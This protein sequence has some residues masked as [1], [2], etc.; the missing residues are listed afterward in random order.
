MGDASRTA[1]SI[2]GRWANSGAITPAGAAVGEL[3][4][5][6]V[7]MPPGAGSAVGASAGAFVGSGAEEL[8]NLA[9][10]LW[11]R[12]ARN[13]DRMVRTAEH[14]AQIPALN[15]LRE[16]SRDPRLVELLAQAA[17]TAARSF[18]DWKIDTLARVFVH[19]ARGEEHVDGAQI[20]L[21]V[22]RQ[23]ERPHLRLMELLLS[24]NPNWNYP[25]S[26]DDTAATHR[27]PTGDIIQVDPGL[28]K[29]LASRLSS[30]RDSVALLRDWH[31]LAT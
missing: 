9:T 14:E 2:V 11:E 29:A 13:V 28:D 1:A 23:L 31:E 17:E 22:V 18:D 20:V 30:E 10:P 16:A 27:W 15:L 25:T 6:G 12:R 5:I 26:D 21:D 4:G 19:G 7:G 24:P 3:I 8:I